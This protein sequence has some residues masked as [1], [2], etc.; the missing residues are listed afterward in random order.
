MAKAPVFLARETYRRRRL[1]DAAR[2]LPFVA[3]FLFL[4]PILW[5]SGSGTAAGKVY[6]FVVWFALILAAAALSRWLAPHV[7]D[8]SPAPGQDSEGE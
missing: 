2:F 7:G 1:Q 8:D 4:I 6:I 3:A 5:A